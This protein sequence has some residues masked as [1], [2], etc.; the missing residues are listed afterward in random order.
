MKK[1]IVSQTR[2]FKPS[3]DDEL[4]LDDTPRVNSFNGVTSDG[5]ARAIAG[6]S[7]EVPVVTEN[8]NGKVLKAIYDEGGP[9]VEWGEVE[10]GA[11]YTGGAGVDI[12]AN[13]AVNVIAGKGIEIGESTVE[14]NVEVYIEDWPVDD[15]KLYH[16]GRLGSNIDVDWLNGGQRTATLLHDFV[17]DPVNTL[18][19]P[20]ICAVDSNDP[21]SF[22]VTQ[23]LVFGEGEVG[24]DENLLPAG[25]DFVVDSTSVNASKSTISLADVL[26]NPGD[27]V[28]TVIP[29]IYGTQ[30]LD[31]SN[32]YYMQGEAKETVNTISLGSSVSNSVKVKNP[33]PDNLADG[34]RVLFSIGRGSAPEWGELASGAGTT[35]S[36]LQVNVNAGK[37][38]E[39]G[40][41]NALDVKAGSG[42]VIGQDTVHA[43]W[44]VPVDS[45]SFTS[46]DY[47]ASMAANARGV[48]Y[49]YNGIIL[50]DA[51]N[52][53]GSMKVTIGQDYFYNGSNDQGIAGVAVVAKDP[54]NPYGIDI[55]NRLFYSGDFVTVQT[56]SVPNG[57]EL[58]FNAYDADGEGLGTITWQ[59]V[60]DAP[61]NY[62]LA[63]LAGDGMGDIDTTAKYTAQL[64]YASGDTFGGEYYEGNFVKLEHPI[65]A[66]AGN[67]GKVLAVN[68]VDAAYGLEWVSQGGGGLPAIG[69]YTLRFKFAD[70]T[71]EPVAGTHSSKG[72][73]TAVDASNGIWDWSYAD[74]DWGYAFRPDT[75]DYTPSL[76]PSIDTWVIDGD[77]TGVVNLHHCFA[78]ANKLKGFKV[79]KGQTGGNS[80]NTTYMFYGCSTLVY[81]DYGEDLFRADTGT[82]TFKECTQLT[83]V[84]V[85]NT[86]SYSAEMFYRC[87]Q[88]RNVTISNLQ[89]D[90]RNMFQLCSTL[91]HVNV[92]YYNNLSFGGTLSHSN[93]MFDY[94]YNLREIPPFMIAPYAN[95][96]CEN[97]FRS[98]G[99][100]QSIPPWVAHMNKTSAKNMFSGCSNL[101]TIPYIKTD[102]VTDVSGMFREC[103]RIESGA[104][105]LYQQM[106]QQA[107]PPATTADCFTN[108]G[109]STPSG[110]AALATIPASW[111]GT[112][113]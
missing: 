91:E 24:W 45:E 19:Y 39:I 7:G 82:G 32:K 44:N 71:F 15:G 11:T 85:I 54:N 46:V 93:E 48:A 106:S 49:E 96:N 104:D 13:N 103:L 6:A 111:G 86:G 26:A 112:G 84:P 105:T 38:L 69:T 59:D 110:T 97:M 87:S 14:D 100:I 66:L 5:V 23:R 28:L 102:S 60:I 94:C 1:Q 73:W 36:G 37:G 50:A 47:L 61:N 79:A 68:S 16:F 58:W 53:Q 80:I 57:T 3:Y 64:N 40:D 83:S 92:L 76:L 30:E 25:Q 27:F 33:V 31:L 113:A 77:M 72:S 62:V 21:N 55:S 56:G 95:Y 81:V 10:T 101:R 74:S 8:D 78:R 9:A 17:T 34:N 4:L 88:I 90:C 89:Y 22:D 65:P 108:C 2:E 109:S 41:G 42:L 63:L 52:L 29:Y 35:A 12:D 70:P 107:T 98:C 67:E 99:L 51:I 18:F 43:A 75:S 20:A